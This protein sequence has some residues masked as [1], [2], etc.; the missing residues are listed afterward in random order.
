MRQVCLLQGRKAREKPQGVG[1]NEH[2]LFSP[3]GPSS[4]IAVARPHVF[5]SPSWEVRVASPYPTNIIP[6]VCPELV[7]P[8]KEQRPQTL[9]RHSRQRER[10]PGIA[11][12]RLRVLRLDRSSKILLNF[13]EVKPSPT[14]LRGCPG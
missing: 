2:N 5:Y 13:V 11:Q 3:R 7:P 4:Y 9:S 6:G 1:N 14:N 10:Y 8:Q 12:A